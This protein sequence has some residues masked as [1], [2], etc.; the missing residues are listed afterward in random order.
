MNI[1][2]FL[3]TLESIQPFFTVK[4]VESIPINIHNL[5]IVYGIIG[6]SARMR[7]HMAWRFVSALLFCVGT[8]KHQTCFAFFF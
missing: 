3:T 4:Y 5:F 8:K 6:C 2:L 7:F 1:N